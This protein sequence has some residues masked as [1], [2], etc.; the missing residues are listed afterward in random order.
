[1]W[2][3]LKIRRCYLDPSTELKSTPVFFLFL[4]QGRRYRLFGFPGS[5]SIC[6]HLPELFWAQIEI[7]LVLQRELAAGFDR[8]WQRCRILAWSFLMM[9]IVASVNGKTAQFLARSVRRKRQTSLVN[10]PFGQC[11][12]VVMPETTR[13]RLQNASKK[14]II[15]DFYPF[16]TCPFPRYVKKS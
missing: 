8:Q 4:Y 3:P 13:P 9:K 11:A 6:Q 12:Q 5:W 2:H 7:G 16:Y 1:M 14:A 15:W 10:D